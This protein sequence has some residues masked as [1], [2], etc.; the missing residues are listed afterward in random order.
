MRNGDLM[1][2]GLM[3]MSSGGLPVCAC[4]CACVCVPVRERA[5]ERNGERKKEMK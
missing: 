1:L 5:C 2:A 3:E 4:A